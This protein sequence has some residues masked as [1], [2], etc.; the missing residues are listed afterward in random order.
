[1]RREEGDKLECRGGGDVLAWNAERLIDGSLGNGKNAC[2]L[3]G[4][5]EGGRSRQTRLTAG[6]QAQKAKLGSVIPR[7]DPKPRQRQTNKLAHLI[8]SNLDYLIRSV[9]EDGWGGLDGRAR[10]A[11]S[12]WW[13]EGGF[14]SW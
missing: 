1:M 4:E 8:M 9:E 5:S 10:E 2:G 13:L 6:L 11:L 7:R 12:S 3:V 14:S